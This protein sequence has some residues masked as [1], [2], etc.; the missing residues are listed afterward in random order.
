MTCLLS[1]R[2]ERTEQAARHGNANSRVEVGE[3]VVEERARHHHV[4]LGVDDGAASCQQCEKI[5]AS[6]L[7]AAPG[8][9]EGPLR[10]RE[11]PLTLHLESE[12]C[13]SD[14]GLGGDDIRINLHAYAFDLRR[15]GRHVLLLSIAPAA[16]S[17]PKPRER[18]ARVHAVAVEG[19]NRGRGEVR[20]AQGE[21]W[22]RRLSL[23][24]AKLELLR[25]LLGAG[26]TKLGAGGACRRK[27]HLLRPRGNLRFA[28]YRGSQRRRWTTAQQGVD[29]RSCTLYESR[30]RHEVCLHPCKLD[31]SQRDLRKGATRRLPSLG[32]GED[33]ASHVLMVGVDAVASRSLGIV[34][35]SMLGIACDLPRSFGGRR[36]VHSRLLASCRFTRSEG[37][38]SRERLTDADHDHLRVT[39]G[40]RA[41]QGNLP[42]LAHHLWGW[43][44]ALPVGGGLRRPRPLTRRAHRWIARDYQA[45][46]S[47]SVEGAREV[48]VDV[49]GWL[50][51]GHEWHDERGAG[52]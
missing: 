38:R 11:N 32:N 10:G 23:H 48:R 45:Y 17:A 33:V 25:L 47:A 39:E 24:G 4:V 28:V 20:D 46:E 8:E 26:G 3:R 52:N 44:P 2:S 29:S 36:L 51:A 7:V 30:I 12:R 27:N 43:Q 21:A 40:V 41:S 13:G 31:F 6:A 37:P 14:V 34:R 19:H 42:D 16:R 18:H 49:W 50:C 5:G 1:I 35:E 15:R 9:T 22:P